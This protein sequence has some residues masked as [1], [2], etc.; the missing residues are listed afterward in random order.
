M[1]AIPCGCNINGT[2]YLIPLLLLL[3]FRHLTEFVGLDMEMA[4]KFHYHEVVD[5][6]GNMFTQIFKGRVTSFRAD[7]TKPD[8]SAKLWT[9]MRNLNC[10]FLYELNTIVRLLCNLLN[11]TIVGIP[12]F[13]NIL[14][15]IYKK[16]ITTLPNLQKL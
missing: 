3:L 5:T 16:A 15:F 2:V 6:I 4:F 11:D 8:K 7:N 10:F 13:D 14:Q 1:G 9:R 12:F